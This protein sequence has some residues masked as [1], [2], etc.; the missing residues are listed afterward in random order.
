M[1]A[2]GMK[3]FEGRY[4]NPGSAA[5]F[6]VLFDFSLW[7]ISAGDGVLLM[8]PGW[9]ILPD[10]PWDPVTGCTPDFVGD[11]DWCDFPPSVNPGASGGSGGPPGSV[12]VAIPWSAFAGC[13]GCPPG[14]GPGVD[15]R[16]TMTILRGT[17]TLDFTPDGAI[18]DV[19]SEVVSGTTT[20]T[21]DGCNFADKIDNTACEI[22]EKHGSVDAYLPLQP[23]LTHELGVGG[24]AGTLLIDKAGGSSIELDWGTSCAV[25]DTAYAVY[26]GTVGNWY[27]HSP[28]TGLCP[29][30]GG[31]SATFVPAAGDTYYLVV[32]TAGTSEGSYGEDSSSTERPVSAAACAPSQVL[33]I[34]Y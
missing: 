14:F 29:N 19:L 22:A 33:G 5:D 24:R 9:T 15:F 20:L 25:G 28:L 10:S 1:G 23:P 7:L 21:P 32:P 11:N 30:G 17:L 2:G 3:P 27:S 13:T 18:E 6:L 12:E 34:C 26:E 31:T 16:F 8:Q 4:S